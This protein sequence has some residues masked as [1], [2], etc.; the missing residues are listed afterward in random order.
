MGGLPLRDHP[1]HERLDAVDHAPEVHAEDP[2][3]VAMRGR[4]ET[5]PQRDARVV[6]EHVH[7]A[8]GRDR[9]VGQRLD[10]RE[11]R[12]VGTDTERLAAAAP[13][14]RDGLREGALVDIGDDHL[15]ALARE[16]LDHGA[17]DPAPSTRH[18]R[19][20]TREISH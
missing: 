19:N 9:A 5:A 2:L 8:E 16:A 11:L 6:A 18:H 13:H 7:L 20:P 10:R 17:A 14:G 15:R 1:R 3:P 12:H 4:L